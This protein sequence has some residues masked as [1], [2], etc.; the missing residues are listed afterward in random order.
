M[1]Y[2]YKALKVNGKRIDEHRYIMQEFLGRKLKRYEIVHHKNGN[3][4]DN[5]LENLE[6]QKLSDHS[7]QFMTGRPSPLLGRSIITHK[8]KNGKYWCSRCKKYLSKDKF[9]YDY[10]SKYHIRACCKKH[11]LNGE[12]K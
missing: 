9:Y 8:Y 4:K 11:Y 5:R 7:C 6:V 3:K 1:S 10:S 2:E 12:Q